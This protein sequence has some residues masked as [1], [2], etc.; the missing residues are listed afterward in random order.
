MA[1]ISEPGS[2]RWSQATAYSMHAPRK[3]APIRIKARSNIDLSRSGG[4]Q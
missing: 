4:G 2:Y 1:M 3:T